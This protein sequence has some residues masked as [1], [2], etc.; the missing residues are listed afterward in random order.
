MA[1]DNKQIGVLGY[2]CGMGAGTFGTK[3]GPKAL[4]DR[5]LI[6]HL[7]QLGYTVKDFGDAT[8]DI[9][10]LNDVELLARSSADEKKTKNLF[11]VYAATKQTYENTTQALSEGYF[12]LHLGGDH[13]S[14]IGFLSAACDHYKD[15]DLSVIWLDAHADINNPDTSP[16]QNLHGM[17]AAVITGQMPGL[18]SSVF[19]KQPALKPENLIFVGLRD[20]DAGERQRIKDLG[21]HAFTMKDIDINGMAAVVDE[22]IG[23]ATKNSPGF[24]VSFDLDVCD[25]LLVPGTG[26]PYRGGLTFR[27]TH[28]AAELIADSG[29]MLGFELTELNPSLD[30]KHKTTDLALSV[31]ETALGKAIL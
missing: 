4:R 10:G 27:E 7:E 23:L 24:L 14:G 2:A 19:Q 22:A 12:P 29:K 6:A 21:V 13:S 1:E 3:D 31:I 26:T 15:D 16:S 28:L 11:Q 25:P 5:G 17:S 20:L 30:E 18:L 8:P 9:E